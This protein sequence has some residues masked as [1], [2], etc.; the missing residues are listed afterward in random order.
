MTEWH[1]LRDGSGFRFIFPKFSRESTEMPRIEIKYPNGR[2][3]SSIFK[4]GKRQ[5][6]G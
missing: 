6:D 4:I 1:W 3:A 2:V 5:K